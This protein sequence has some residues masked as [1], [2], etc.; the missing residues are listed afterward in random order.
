MS[1]FLNRLEWR[2]ATKK[3]D[4]KYKLPEADLGKILAAIRMAPTSFGLQ[5]FYVRVVTSAETKRKLQEAGWNQPQFST[6][7]AALVFVARGDVMDRIEE[8]MR[9]RTKGDAQ[10]RQ[11]LAEY[12]AMMKGFVS[13]IGPDKATAWAQR[14][15]YIALGFALAACAE[16]GVDS[17][18]MEGFSPDEFNRILGLPAHHH[19]TAV[20]TVGK[21]AGDS[22]A[23]PKWRFPESDLIKFG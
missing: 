12:E 16:L 9:D 8:M 17:C 6:S 15:V 10:A 5:P 23:Y 3:F 22:S 13:A 18:P 7:S 4:E 21:V 2:S 14:Q 1:S 20:L 11:Q 19:A